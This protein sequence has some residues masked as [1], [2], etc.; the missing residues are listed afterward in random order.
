MCPGGNA[1]SATPAP[2]DGGNPKCRE[3]MKKTFDENSLNYSTI[4]KLITF[5]LGFY[6]SNIINRWWHKVRSIPK[7]EN[8]SLVLCGLTWEEEGKKTEELTSP[9]AVAEAKKMVARY[10][11]LS[12]AMCLTTISNSFADTVGTTKALKERG[13]LTEDELAAL[14]APEGKSGPEDNFL[15]DLWWVPLTWTTNLLSRMGVNAE[16]A[17]RIIPKDH[18]DVISSVQK[19]KKEL[20]N[21]KTCGDHRLPSF[22]KTVI[23]R[24]IY[25]WVIFSVICCQQT[26][27]HE[28]KASMAVMLV[29][30]FPATAI[31]VQTIL[32]GWLYMAD[33]LE[34]P[35]GTHPKYDID[36][37]EELELNIWR[38]SVTLQHQNVSNVATEEEREKLRKKIW[39]VIKPA[40]A[41]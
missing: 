30:N 37:D 21:Q 10:C 14:Q 16:K 26:S 40:P 8:P 31:L 6:V 22:Y 5:L 17:K 7:V 29:A 19:F 15:A 33:I 38:C 25:G 41:S 4:T 12:W 20:E 11:L 3:W 34:N 27:H 24:A 9:P 23:H 1:S 35:Y 13:L 36:L 32:L 18:K 2:V 39:E 28:G